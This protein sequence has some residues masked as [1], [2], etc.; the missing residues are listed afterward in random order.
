V[1]LLFDVDGTL[2]GRA[3]G[4]HSR[5]LRAALLRVHGVDPDGLGLRIDPAG[6]TDNEIARLLLL[7]AGVPAKEIDR[8]RHDVREACCRIY[9][10]LCPPSLADKVLPGVADLLNWLEGEAGVQLS[11]VTGN[12]EPVARLKLTRAGLGAHFAHGQGGFGSDSEDRTDLPHIARKR[13]GVNGVAHPRE[14]TIVIG[15]TPRD[16]ICA[17]ADGVRCLAVATGPYGVDELSDADGVAAGAAELRP[18][19]AAALAG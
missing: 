6:R 7:D 2:V 16:I 13:A 4:E 5:A 8:H 1:L 11:L 17:R 14:D 12:F 19:L 15:D 10:E 18:L 3:T 9:A